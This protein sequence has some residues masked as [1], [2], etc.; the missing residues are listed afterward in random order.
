LY[1]IQDDT[2][3]QHNLYADYPVIVEELRALLEQ[4]IINGYSVKRNYK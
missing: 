3:E 4:Y 2:G 1:N